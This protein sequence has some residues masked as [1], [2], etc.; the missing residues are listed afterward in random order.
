[1]PKLYKILHGDSSCHGGTHTWSLP[2]QLPDGSWEPGQWHEITEKTVSLCKSGFHLT[3]KPYE[4]YIWG[5]TRYE[6]EG[7]GE[8][9]I[10]IDKAAFQRARLLRPVQHPQWW[11]NAVAFVESLGSFRLFESENEPLPQ[12]RVFKSHDG[13]QIRAEREGWRRDKA[14]E[15]ATDAALDAARGAARGAARSAA[16]DAAR[17]AARSA[18][19][20]ATWDTTRYP[21]RIAARRAAWDA[22]LL[23]GALVAEKGVRYARSRWAVWAAGF[24]LYGD[25]NGTLYVY[26]RP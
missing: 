24:G 1:M 25:V 18:A 15:A 4:W 13:A 9:K 7:A 3:R 23:A 12:W 6:A 22:D 11:L 8:S 17:N 21:E 10:G 2:V 26:K 16:R 14:S 19:R 20:N 5:C